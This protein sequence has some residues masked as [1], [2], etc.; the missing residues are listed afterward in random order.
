MI[1]HPDINEESLHIPKLFSS[2]VIHKYTNG[3]PFGSF[4]DDYL[5]IMP[6][7]KQLIDFYDPIN[8]QFNHRLYSQLYYPASYDGKYFNCLHEMTSYV[9]M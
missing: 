1:N 9:G 5:L 8:K 6:N 4:G 3:F 7:K 2:K